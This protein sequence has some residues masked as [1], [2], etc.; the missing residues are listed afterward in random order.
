MSQSSTSRAYFWRTTSATS[1]GGTCACELLYSPALSSGSS[2]SNSAS[3][4]FT[5]PTVAMH[6]TTPLAR[7]FKPTIVFGTHAHV[8]LRAHQPLV[9]LAHDAEEA[10]AL[11]PRVAARDQVV[12]T[13]LCRHDDLRARL[14]RKLQIIGRGPPMPAA[15]TDVRLT[16]GSRLS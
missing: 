6:M 12:D 1:G 5:P 4:A 16:P 11:E 8:I 2:A 9:R 15:M 13:G 10:R 14:P 3:S 7:V